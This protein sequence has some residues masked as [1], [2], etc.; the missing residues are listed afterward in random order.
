MPGK[1]NAICAVQENT[2]LHQ[3]KHHAFYV[4]QGSIQHRLEVQ[5]ACIVEW[6]HFNN[7]LARVLAYYVTLENISMKQVIW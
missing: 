5:S 6:G 7:Q 1:V 3:D 2:N 4:G